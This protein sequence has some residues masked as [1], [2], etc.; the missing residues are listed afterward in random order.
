MKKQKPYN[1]LRI[2]TYL[3]DPVVRLRLPAV[4]LRPPLFLAVLL[5]RALP[6][7]AVP[8][9]LGVA[10][11]LSVVERLRLVL[12]VAFLR[13]VLVVLL[14]AVVLVAAFL[15][16]AVLLFLAVA[17]FFAVA[18]F[19]FATVVLVPVLFFVAAFFFG[20]GTLPP[21]SR[22]S[23]SPMAMACLRLVTFLPEPDFKV[24]FFISR[25][26]FSTFSDA[27]FPYFAIIC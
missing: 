14:V 26:V 19:F 6:P 17:D 21:A 11:R 3:P 15:R 7:L 5:L 13:V 10:L 22:A 12:A 4:P 25:I 27:F 20:A 18:V 24:P 23:L 2:Q 9:L 16:V 8:R 1:K